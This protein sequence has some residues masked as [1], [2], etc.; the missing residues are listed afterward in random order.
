MTYKIDPDESL[1]KVNIVP[2]I[3]KVIILF[4]IFTNILVVIDIPYAR[5]IFGFIYLTFIPGL[6]FLLAFKLWQG[7]YLE[8]LL[9]SIGLD[10]ALLLFIGLLVNEL[11]PIFNFNYPLSTEP[12]LIV[13]NIF[14]I[15]SC[16]I[17][18]KID[19]KNILKFSIPSIN[20]KPLVFIMVIPAL[21]ILGDVVVNNDGTNKLLLL[22]LALV[23]LFM[24]ISIINK[25]FL[26]NNLYALAIFAITFALIFHTSLITNYLIGW[27]Y[28]SEYQVFKLVDNKAIWDYSF[29][30]SDVNIAKGYSM[31]SVTILP[32]IYSKVA[33]IDGTTIFKV[34]YSL[35]L[36]LIPLCLYKFYSER[37]K[38]K[39][40][41]LAIFF[42]ISNL[43]FFSIEGFSATQIVGE[44]FYVLIFLII[45]KN[46]ITPSKKWLF[47]VLFS[48][49]LVISYYSLSYIL[50]FFLF[51]PYFIVS[52]LSTFKILRKY[53]TL[54]M[55]L[56]FFII[57]FTMYIY[58]NSSI[59]VLN[60]GTILQQIYL[61]FGKDFF[62]LA[63]RSATVLSGLG[64]SQASSFLHLVGRIFFYVAEFFILIGFAKILLFK[65]N[66]EDFQIDREYVIFALLNLV[67]LIM[68]IVIPNFARFFR[69]ERFY[70]IS[71]LFLAPFFV[72]GGSIFFKFF[73]RRK[74]ILLTINL[75]LIVLIPLFL[76]ETGFFYE[77][78]GDSSYS[79]PLSMYRMDKVSLYYRIIDKKEIDAAVWLSDNMN[80]SNSLVYGDSISTLRVLTSY[81]MLNGEN[82]RELTNTTK[83]ESNIN[84]VYLREVNT[85]ENTIIA[86]NG[87]W[88]LSDISPLMKGHSTIYSNGPDKIYFLDR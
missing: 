31:L 10:I 64:L 33:A 84:Y 82:Y 44:F 61:N 81:G 40:S 38:N 59:Q 46:N 67:I 34:F 36:S 66:D 73:L 21:S 51:L 85:E 49:A 20:I 50:L 30:S 78:T 57:T 24:S 58:S 19:D 69:A 15:A 5:Q 26:P 14:V 11:L 18:T 1:I 25:K 65:N 47:F 29:T 16:L 52:E 68:C 83:F 41:L 53:I 74:N 70:Q 76:F 75:I 87:S 22:M 48:S 2:F 43:T 35:L 8:T 7:D 17:I 80:R 12:L 72:H 6:V 4:Q 9:I 45:L 86:E 27:D 37:M 60:L 32:T 42:L 39:I 54:E 71:L 56:L 63:A 28:Q 88:S 55:L 62:N 13:L 79:L 3:V 77:M 23:A